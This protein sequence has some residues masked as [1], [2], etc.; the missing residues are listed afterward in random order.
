[1]TYSNQ[2]RLPYASDGIR[3]HSSKA[4]DS[5]GKFAMLCFLCRHVGLLFGKKLDTN[6]LRL[7]IRKYP[8]SPVHTLLDS[9]RIYFFPLWRAHFKMSGFA[10]QF[11][12][13]VWT[14]ALCGKNKLWIQK[15]PD[16][17]TGPKFFVACFCSLFWP[18]RA[19]NTLII[20]YSVLR[21]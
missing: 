8:D 13:C 4:R 10:V 2:I 9:L 15:Y 19:Q 14:E 3:I 6:L 21:D 1:M 20:V 17:W 12:G 11:A 5:G 18:C 16:L 7:W